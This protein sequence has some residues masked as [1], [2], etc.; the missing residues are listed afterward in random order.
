MGAPDDYGRSGWLW[1]L[2]MAMGALDDLN[3]LNYQWTENE[4]EKLLGIQ[5]KMYGGKMM[6]RKIIQK[7]RGILLPL[8]NQDF[9]QNYFLDDLWSAIM[10]AIAS[11]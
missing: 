9:W 6:I 8:L 11:S 5:I 1:A 10:Y 7:N 3:Y 4:S 2:R